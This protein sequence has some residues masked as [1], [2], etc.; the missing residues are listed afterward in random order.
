[1]IVAQIHAAGASRK[2]RF[3]RNSVQRRPTADRAITN[4]EMTKNN[5]TPIQPTRASAL[6]SKRHGTP[7]RTNALCG[8]GDAQ[9]T[10][11]KWFPSTS[12]AQAKRNRSTAMIVPSPDFLIRAYCLRVT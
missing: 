1:V 6:P 7:A 9:K 11:P 5:S 12:K 10:I 2:V 8:L 3:H 4:P